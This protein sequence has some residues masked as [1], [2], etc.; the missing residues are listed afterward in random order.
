M[1]GKI[2]VVNEG[3]CTKILSAHEDFSDT[4][5]LVSEVLQDLYHRV[6]HRVLALFNV[7]QQGLV[8]SRV[9]WRG[10]IFSQYLFP[11]HVSAL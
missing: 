2:L 8:N 3:Y 9:D 6:G 10:L 11:L 5:R 4:N 1:T 7:G